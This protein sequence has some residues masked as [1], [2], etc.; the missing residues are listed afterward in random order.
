MPPAILKL[1]PNS[2]SRH[3]VLSYNLAAAE[4]SGM[5]TRKFT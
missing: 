4:I 5:L 3:F 2:A 1:R